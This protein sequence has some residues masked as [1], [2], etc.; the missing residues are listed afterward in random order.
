MFGKSLKSSLRRGFTLIEIMIVVLII[1][2]LL[3]I[4]VPNFVKARES[5]RTK[6]CVANLKQIQSAK[7]QWAMDN[8]QPGTAAPAAG[9]LYGTGNYIPGPAAGPVCPANNAAYTIGTVDTNPTCSYFA[10]NP[11]HVLP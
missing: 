9:V 5:S 1:G 7:E 4:A 11:E 8:R 6:A 10:T 3:A 2:I